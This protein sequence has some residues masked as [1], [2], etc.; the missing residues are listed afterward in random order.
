MLEALKKRV[1]GMIPGTTMNVALAKRQMEREL[2]EQGYSRSHAQALAS[3]H[4][5][6][7]A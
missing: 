2:R 4:F 6:K 1:V 3:Q 7:G 5:K